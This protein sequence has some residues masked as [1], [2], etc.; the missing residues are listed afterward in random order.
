MESLAC[1]LPVVATDNRGHRELIKNGYNGYLV[2]SDD[3]D[4][5]ARKVSALIWD[6]EKFKRLSENASNSVAI[7]R[8]CSVLEEMK[9]IYGGL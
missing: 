2:Q 6:K 3:C 9:D 8:S 7:Y 4:E 5:F 1:G